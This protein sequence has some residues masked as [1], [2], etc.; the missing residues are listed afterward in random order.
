MG[1]SF[2]ASC[3]ESE[4]NPRDWLHDVLLRIND[5]PVNRLNGLL[6]A[7]WAKARKSRT[8]EEE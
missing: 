3:Q 1:Y 6:P 5:H 8:S 7:Q 2:F 4:V